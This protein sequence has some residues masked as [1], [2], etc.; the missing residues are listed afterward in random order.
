MKVKGIDLKFPRINIFLSYFL[1][2]VILFI[3]F[4]F[5]LPFTR[6]NDCEFSWQFQLFLTIM[7][8][9]LTYSSFNTH[10]AAQNKIAGKPILSMIYLILNSLPLTISLLILSWIPFYFIKLITSAM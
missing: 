6:C 5:L 10:I 7:G 8:I 3:W 9:S 2:I 1:S 4:S